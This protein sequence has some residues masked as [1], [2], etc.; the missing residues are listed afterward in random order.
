MWNHMSSTFVRFRGQGFEAND[1]ALEVWL[2]LLVREI[3]KMD[4]VPDWLH[5]VRDEWYLQSTSGF[6]FGVMPRLDDFVTSEERRKS[7]LTLSRQ[8]LKKLE[9]YG[10]V[11]PREELNS[12]KTG[13]KNSIFTQDVP[14][15]ELARPAR[16]FIKLLEGNLAA[17]E[18]DSRFEPGVKR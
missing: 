16:Y 9:S 18:S 5:E 12:L 2:A 6:G 4:L 1:T 14:I 3:D 7:I 15:S 17:W 8:A 13:G 10:Q 11:V